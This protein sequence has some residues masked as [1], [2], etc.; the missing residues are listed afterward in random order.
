ML[1]ADQLNELRI[2]PAISYTSI[3]FHKELIVQ[4]SIG[5][6]LDADFDTVDK[7]V[8]AIF[9]DMTYRKKPF[10][11]T[12]YGKVYEL[13]TIEAKDAEINILMIKT[14]DKPHG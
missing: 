3:A 4:V 9:P 8:K 6:T 5:S 1:I 14:E 13:H 7:L 10:I 2:H 11:S 12:E